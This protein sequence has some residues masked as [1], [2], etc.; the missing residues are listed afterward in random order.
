VLLVLPSGQN[1][2]NVRLGGL[3]EELKHVESEIKKLA[4]DL[5]KVRGAVHQLG[6]PLTV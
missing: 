2:C 5:K 4:P 1:A 6:G 3:K